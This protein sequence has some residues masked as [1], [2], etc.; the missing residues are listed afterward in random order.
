M[1]SPIP[2]TAVVPPVAGWCDLSAGVGGVG[3]GLDAFCDRV[4]IRGLAV[5]HLTPGRNFPVLG[6]L[7]GDF[8]AIILLRECPIRAVGAIRL[9]VARLIAPR[10]STYR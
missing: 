6:A 8:G 9:T 5:R 10:E 7:T 4:C 3:G 1:G 2:C